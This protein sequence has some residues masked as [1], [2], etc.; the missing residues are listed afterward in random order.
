VKVAMSL[1]SAERIKT[2]RS[3][4]DLSHFCFTQRLEE[5]SMVQFQ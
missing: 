5:R 2:A 3:Q 1:L 4:H